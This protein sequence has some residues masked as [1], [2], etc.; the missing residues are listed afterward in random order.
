MTAG[1]KTWDIMSIN[2]SNSAQ[3]SMSSSTAQES[4]K[5]VCYLC[6]C[7][8]LAFLVHVG[9]ANFSKQIISFDVFQ[10]PSCGLSSM[11][12]MA[13]S[14]DLDMLY[15]KEM[16]FA[17]WK[18]DATNI[19]RFLSGFFEP[20]YQRWGTYW[21]WIADRC[22]RKWRHG[23]N[24]GVK[25]RIL[26]VGCGTGR[27]L[28]EFIRLEPEA[29]LVGIDKDP[30]SREKADPSVAKTIQITNF[31]D[32]PSPDATFDIVTFCFVA[33]HLTDFMAYFKRAAALLSRDGLL[34][35][36]VP[37]IDSPKARSQGQTWP[38]LN[39]PYHKTGHVYWFNRLS[40]ERVISSL[41]LMPLEIRRRGECFYH[42]PRPIQKG[43]MRMLGSMHSLNGVRFIKNYQFRISYAII[44]D[45]LLSSW[46][47]CGDCL[48]CFCVKAH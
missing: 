47:D 4:S 16:I 19:G 43:L 15:E 3:P 6:G 8:E 34:F 24:C 10:C 31:L 40:V 17:N 1:L 35:F 46:F 13:T 23:K 48:Y 32:W 37:D 22:L 14:D 7:Q 9:N 36:S 2:N 30:G 44:I 11:V 33:E 5:K 28:S 45:G 27:L 42:F 25:P 26:D 41:Q 39:D 12:P 38:L 20:A 21:P 29:S 18:S